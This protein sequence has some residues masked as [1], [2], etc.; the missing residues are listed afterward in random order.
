MQNFKTFILMA[1]IFYTVFGNT[2]A[3]ERLILRYTDNYTEI[4]RLK[5]QNREIKEIYGEI[6][7]I[8]PETVQLESDGKNILYKLS[9]E[10][11]IFCNGLPSIWEAVRPVAD[12]AYFESK[13]LVNEFNEVLLIN[14]YYYG[15]PCVINGWDSVNGTLRLSVYIPNSSATKNFILSNSA[16]LPKESNWLSEEREVFLLYNYKQEIRAVFLPE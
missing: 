2:F 5:L 7:S 16:R 15:E 11:K 1:L 6:V 12:G 9:P 3:S 14:A 4:M 8:A 13:V 10:A